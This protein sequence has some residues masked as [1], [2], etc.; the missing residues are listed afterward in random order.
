MVNTKKA[1]QILWKDT[2]KII[3]KNQEITDPDDHTTNYEDVVIVENEP[4]KLSF[5]TLKSAAADNV[6]SKVEQKAKLFIT[7]EIEIPPGSIVRVTRGTRVFVFSS[8]GIPGIF[9]NHQEIMLE[10]E[11][12][13]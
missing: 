3:A 9:S 4:C 7:N 11:D 2:C 6:K 8:T 12:F 5:E 10:T 13:A 1:L